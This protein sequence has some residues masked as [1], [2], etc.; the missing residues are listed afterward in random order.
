LDLEIKFA[1]PSQRE[2]FYATARNQC[3]SGGFNNGK[4]FGACL[5]AF[6]LLATFPRYRMM[7][8]RQTYA[9]LKKTT[10]ETFFKICPRDF[11]KRHN[12]QDGF[13]ELMNGSTILWMHLDKVEESSLRGLEINSALVDQAEETEEKV[14][15]ILDARI[16]RWD[17]AE[18]PSPM[19]EAYEKECSEKWPTNELTGKYIAPSYLWLLVN[20]DTQFHYIYRRYHPDS[21][22]KNKD[23]FFVEGEWDQGLGSQEGYDAALRHDDEWVDKYVRGKW[24]ISQA[25]IHRV[26]SQS[27]LEYDPKFIELLRR[28]GNL[29]RSMDHGET[30]PTCNLWFSAFSGV[31]IGYREYYV[32][33]KVISEH[34]QAINDLSEGEIYSASYADPSIF[35]KESQKNGGFWTVADEYL[36]KDIPGKSIAWIAADNNEFATRNRINE[37][38]KPSDRYK[39]P[40]T[41]ETPAPGIYFIK[42]SIEYPDGCFHAI[43]QLGSQ[44]RL[45]LGYEN[46]KAI[47]CDDR[48]GKV[49]DHAYDP[50]RYFVSMHGSGTREPARKPPARS[51]KAYLN[52]VKKRKNTMG[53]LSVQ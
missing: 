42:K 39:H 50:T 37:L 26:H 52:M 6:S 25:Q 8:A 36:T 40:L 20:P 31:F 29:Y 44:R 49:T 15:D 13:T 19:L 28:K 21:L 27:L 38:L 53:A 34:R 17:N 5:K 3:F 4:S 48:D 7:I 35:H 22:E 2:F 24:G 33:N 10:M 51:I 14:Y 45:L 11:V 43:N 18:I 41:G 12:E 9:D 16:G 32:P 1:N 46:G 47:Y 23:Y 30:S